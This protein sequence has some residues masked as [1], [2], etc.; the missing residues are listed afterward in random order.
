M[1]KTVKNDW[2]QYF[3]QTNCM[4]LHYLADVLLTLKKI[5]LAASDKIELRA[6]KSKNQPQQLTETDLCFRRNCMK[7]GSCMDLI[8]DDLFKRLWVAK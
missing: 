7:A 3:P 6:F 1:K 5:P 4:W 8:W 2:K